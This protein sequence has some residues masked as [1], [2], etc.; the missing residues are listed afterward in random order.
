MHRWNDGFRIGNRSGFALEANFSQ[1]TSR[2]TRRLGIGCFLRRLA[3]RCIE[4]ICQGCEWTCYR[5][6]VSKYCIHLIVYYVY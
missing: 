6:N 3:N 4:I 2:G 1:R 5:F